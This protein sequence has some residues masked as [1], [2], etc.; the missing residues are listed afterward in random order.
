MTAATTE[1]VRVWLPKA[2]A[3]VAARL[4]RADDLEYQLGMAAFNWSRGEPLQLKQVRN[5]DGVTANVVVTGLRPIPP[6]VALQFSEAIHHLRAA[7][8]NVVFHL[9]TD[10]RGATLPDDEARLVAM[11]IYPSGAKF[12]RWAQRVGAKVPELAPGTTL[13]ARIESLQPYVSSHAVPSIPAQ[14]TPFMGAGQQEHPLLLLQAYSN[15]DK[16]QSMRL[17]TG[18][19]LFQGSD[20]PFGSKPLAMRAVN[21]GEVVVT[22]RLDQPTILESNAAVHVYRPDDATTVAPGAELDYLHAFVAETAIPTLVTGSAAAAPAL[23]C[24]VRLDDTGETLEERVEHGSDWFSAK[25]RVQAEIDQ[26]ML[27]IGAQPVP[28]LRVED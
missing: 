26:A 12:Q 24:Q 5:D 16:H 15:S 11:P 7:L 10:A 21:E 27:E 28:V 18:L 8:D 23:A 9:V 1:T 13:I 22:V 19:T 14:L 6:V 3:P 20:E 4:G 17:A 25:V 2:L